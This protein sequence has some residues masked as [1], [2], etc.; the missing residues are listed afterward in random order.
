MTKEEAKQKVARLVKKYENL[1]S[2]EIKKQNEEA[3]KQGFI[4]PLFK[5][6]VRPHW[7]PIVRQF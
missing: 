5:S 6:L 1:S 7:K 4:L 2:A 3:T